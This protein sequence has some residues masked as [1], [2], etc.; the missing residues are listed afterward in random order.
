MEVVVAGWS[1]QWTARRRLAAGSL[2]CTPPLSSIRRWTC[3]ISRFNYSATTPLSSRT[4]S[5]S[6]I[7][8]LAR[9]YR[10]LCWGRG[11][12][13]GIDQS[14]G[15]A[16]HFPSSAAATAPHAFLIKESLF[17]SLLCFS[18]SPPPAPAHSKSPLTSG[19]VLS[20]RVTPPENHRRTY[21][22][23]G[24]PPR[25]SL[26]LFWFSPLRRRYGAS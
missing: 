9:I 3:S 23:R 17:L 7:P 18:H 25:S 12:G 21:T 26:F 1:L 16:T 10:C 15:V 5:L 6:F 11:G 22:S 20:H 24:R 2:Y 13:D 8:Q 4:F 14:N 19:P